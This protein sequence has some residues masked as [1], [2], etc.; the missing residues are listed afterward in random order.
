MYVENNS[1][2]MG[3]RDGAVIGLGYLAA[4]FAFGI[5]AVSSGMTA[6]Q[7]LLISMLNLTSAGQFAALPI[8]GG[9]GSLVE[10][11]LTQLIINSRYSLMSIS[12][13]QKLGRSVKFSDRL[14]IGFSNTDEIFAFAMEKE[15]YVGRNYMIGIILPA[16]FGWT[17]GT[18]LGAVAGNLLPAVVTTA[19]SVG[20]YA[21]FIALLVPAARKSM[22]TMLCILCAIALSCAFY[23]IK[24]LSVVPSGFVIIIVAV[25]VSALF[26]LL[27]PIEDEEQE[28][29]E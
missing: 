7:A 5:L 24:A 4:S 21:M 17:L 25:S 28:V 29:E 6:L 9:A 16:Y 3:L 11:G 13:S 1:L 18:L 12:L 19:L 26:S 27:F 14:F 2:K 20:M 23:Y 10:L 22:P 8:I 15:G